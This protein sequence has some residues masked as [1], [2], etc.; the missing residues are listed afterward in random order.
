MSGRMG[1]T[2]LKRR[3]LA[4]LSHI[5]K[6]FNVVL[7]LFAYVSASKRIFCGTNAVPYHT[8]QQVDFASSD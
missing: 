7:F 6:A 3:Y 2:N 4:L 5:W 1:E 8:V